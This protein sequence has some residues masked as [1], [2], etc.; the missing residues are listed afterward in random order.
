M[1]SKVNRST[2]QN[3][4]KDNNDNEHGPSVPNSILTYKGKLVNVQNLACSNS[5][6]TTNKLK[7]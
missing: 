7:Q 3:A 4:Q 5:L 1:D 2:L 6:E